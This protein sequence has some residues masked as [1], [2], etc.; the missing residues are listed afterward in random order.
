[1]TYVT[2]RSTGPWSPEPDPG[3]RR[4]RSVVSTILTRCE[5]VI[6]KVCRNFGAELRE[7]NRETD[8]VH[9]LVRYPPSVALSKLVGSL[10]GVSTR[11]LLQDFP[12]HINKCLRGE[13]FWSP[14]YFNRFLR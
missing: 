4:G 5:D 7:F 2:V 11:R 12:D 3:I 6:R 9:L 13:H 8:H 10:K 14:A 1:M